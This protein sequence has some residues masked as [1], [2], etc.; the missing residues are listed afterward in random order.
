MMFV[1]MVLAQVRTTRDDDST[2]PQYLDPGWMPLDELQRCWLTASRIISS[3]TSAT[4]LQQAGAAAQE[5]PRFHT[6]A[7]WDELSEGKQREAFIRLKTWLPHALR[8]LIIEPAE[9]RAD[10]EVR[11]TPTRRPSGWTRWRRLTDPSQLHPGGRTLPVAHEG[12]KDIPERF[13]PMARGPDSQRS[14]ASW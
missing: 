7:E 5:Q 4:L 9:R 10:H 13:V 14:G 3:R 8:E 6:K 1:G 11:L 2:W 12:T